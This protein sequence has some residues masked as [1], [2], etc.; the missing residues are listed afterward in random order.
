[1]DVENLSLAKDFTIKGINVDL[2]TNILLSTDSMSEGNVV[3]DS[4][5]M[6]SFLPNHT[7]QPPPF[8]TPKSAVRRAY[9]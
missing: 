4:V 2:T 7:D 5:G 6:L 9:F 1:M 3:V 8:N